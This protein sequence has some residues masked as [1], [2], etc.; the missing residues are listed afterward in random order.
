MPATFFVTSDFVEHGRGSWID[1]IEAAVEQ[2]EDVRLD[3]PFLD[4][5][6]HARTREEKVALLNAVR[7][8]VKGDSAIDPYEVADEVWRQL[9]IDS[10]DEDDELDRKLTWSDVA[11]I[12]SHELFAV[13]GHGLTHR[14]LGHLTGDEAEREIAESLALLRRAVGGEV[15]QF[16]YPEGMP[17]S[18][19]T[20]VL[21]ALRRHGIET[22][23]V[24][25][26]RPV[27]RGDD[28]LLL[29]RYLVA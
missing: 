15:T 16:S 10:V 18:Y 14:I 29:P 5:A 13:G 12:A 4:G 20:T 23:V 7:T 6:V 19:N 11:E 2:I 1:L 26:H 25:D 3:L 9:G 27:R 22:A 17:S 8:H 21:E 28:P 24:V